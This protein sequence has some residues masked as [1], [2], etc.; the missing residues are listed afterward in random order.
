MKTSLKQPSIFSRLSGFFYAE[1][2]PYG[3]ALSR[4]FLTSAAMTPML[5][6]FPHVR[7]LYSSDGT[8]A[9]LFELYGAANPLPILPPSLAAALF[10]VMIFAMFSAVVGWRTRLA[11]AI[12]L[13][14][15]VYFNLLDC[16]GT[17]TKYSVIA[18]HL[19]TM[20]ALSNCGAVWSVDA[21]LRR[22]T[23]GVAATAVPPR[24]PVWPARLMQILFCF[25]YFGAAVTK[26]QTE[27]FFSGEQM[28]YWM[29]SDWN[30]A[31]PIGEKMAMW[32]PLLL[33]S[34]YITVVWEI[35]FAF[36]VWRPGSRLVVLF[37]GA[38]FH[39]M[40]WM[41]LGLYIFPSI[42][43][44][45]YLAFISERDI[46]VIRSAIR[47]IHFP[48]HLIGRIGDGIARLISYRPASMPMAAVFTACGLVAAVCAT[49]AEYR[50]DAYGM[51]AN[52][53]KMS[54]PQMNRDVALMMIND[55]RQVREQDK[56][57][58]FDLGTVLVGGQLA[59]REREYQIGETIV[60]QC[61]LNPPHEDLW[62]EC[63]LVDDQDRTVSQ[64]GQ[65]VT[66]DMLHANFFYNTCESLV[67][68]RYALMLKSS[69]KDIYKRHFTLTSPTGAAC[70]V[71]ASS[72]DVL[73]N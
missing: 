29:L 34:A 14:V 72:A 21:I 48:V 46:V 9:S 7:E 22:R 17:M 71:P 23:L 64:C 59:N 68:G 45:G 18:T 65:F 67:P 50:M 35:V 30:Y 42:C 51:L 10:G 38:A 1:E 57:F 40:T 70:P 33:I 58:S 8:P 63:V 25:V 15:Y 44:S 39:F 49:E 4:I 73:T 61:N 41:S 19:L 52:N 56:Y 60:A 2:A 54:L 36:L 5:M 26:I 16:V 66:R 55:N 3:L 11:Y 12:G 28:R 69:G 13:P 6:R 53:G 32:A 37:I 27:S 24:F 31:N 62:V 47:R 20:L 43:L